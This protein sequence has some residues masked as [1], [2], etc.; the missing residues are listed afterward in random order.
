MASV[1]TFH[2]KLQTSVYHNQSGC[3]VGDNIEPA[4]VV[5]GTGGYSLCSECARLGG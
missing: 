3:T 4:N 5:S 1:P 2:S